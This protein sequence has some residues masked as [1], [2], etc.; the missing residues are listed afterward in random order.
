[1]KEVVRPSGKYCYPVAN[2]KLEAIQNLRPLDKI[3]LPP[4]S[5]FAPP[6]ERIL[7]EP[8]SV[9]EE[10]TTA[11][12]AGVLP[13]REPPEQFRIKEK[14][15]GLEKAVE[16]FRAAKITTARLDKHGPTIGCQACNDFG[17]SLYDP[18]KHNNACRDRF[19]GLFSRSMSTSSGTAAP[20]L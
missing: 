4:A 3:V 19:N 7:P 15:L 1:V 16:V 11:V 8:P 2:C 18:T 10:L 5:S 6:L 9:V 20:T 12:S 14:A 17:G 13:E